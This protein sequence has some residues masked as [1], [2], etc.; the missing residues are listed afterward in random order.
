MSQQSGGPVG[1]NQ[2]DV[3]HQQIQAAIAK[4]IWKDEKLRNEFV[5]D[6]KGAIE[7]NLGIKFAEGVNVKCIDETDPKTVYYILPHHP[8][9]AL[10]VEFTDEQLDAVAGGFG[11]GSILGIGGGI[12]SGLTGF[13]GGLAQAIGGPGSGTAANILGGISTGATLIGGIGD[14]LPL[15]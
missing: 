5:K 4:V 6:P 8:S 1:Q 2:L 12:V 7:K 9:K 13:A 3:N 10:G 14:I 15:P 11:I